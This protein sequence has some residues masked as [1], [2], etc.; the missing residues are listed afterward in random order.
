MTEPV[1]IE[2]RLHDDFS[3]FLFCIWQH[4]ELPNPTPLQYDIGNYLV[5]DPE[6]MILE[7]FR[8][9]G[10]S[11]ITSAFVLWIVSRRSAR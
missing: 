9:C 2:K 5:R 7:A 10:K 6:R 4:F 11:F 8:E 1:D 3:F